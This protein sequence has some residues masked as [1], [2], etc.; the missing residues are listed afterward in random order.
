[1]PEQ[2]YH[3]QHDSKMEK[4]SA[5]LKEI[6]QREDTA[7]MHNIQLD[8]AKTQQDLLTQDLNKGREMS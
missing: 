7:S 6:D 4:L 5:L 3:P 8:A 2:E 1:M